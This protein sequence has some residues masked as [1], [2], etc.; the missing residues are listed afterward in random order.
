MRVF[1]EVRTGPNASRILEVPTGPAVKVGRTPPADIVLTGDPTMS[2]L[3]FGLQFDGHRCRIQNLKSL[4]GILIN[5]DAVTEA[6]LNDGDEI[7]A[8][9]TKLV[10]RY[11]TAPAGSRSSSPVSG[12]P[13]TAAAGRPRGS[14][15]ERIVTALR[16]APGS[17]FAI[18]DAARDPLMVL[19]RLFDA[20]D[21]HQSL[22]EGPQAELLA[23]TAPYLVSL[24][25]GS[26]LL[27]TLVRD[28]WGK[29]WSLY[30]TCD[31]PFPEVRKH[32][33]RFLVVRTED[34]EELLFRYYD[35]RVL[36]S[37]L[38]TCTSDELA[39]LFGPVRSFLLEAAQP[40]TLLRFEF[41]SGRLKQHATPLI[42]DARTDDKAT[43]EKSVLV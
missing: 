39:K 42:D 23:A 40:H 18:L 41:E 20:K 17:L 5:G 24:P 21:E 4:A 32:L 1:L 29:S 2:R 27:E 25:V 19:T 7:T 14:V 13:G 10:V 15:T 34:G 31:R 26:P 3:H 36:R 11:E 38:P 22:Y 37:F 30:F 35:P 43:V 8:G 6:V 33:R 16:Q 12:A 9:S 28:G